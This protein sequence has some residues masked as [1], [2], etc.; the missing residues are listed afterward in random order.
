MLG[1]GISLW[2]QRRAA[3]A[4]L[5]PATLSPHLWLDPSDLTTLF[6]NSNGTGAVAADN[7]PVGYIGDKSGNGN[8]FIEA[9]AAARPIYKTSAGLSWLAF[10]GVDDSIGGPLVNGFITEAV[11]DIFCAGIVNTIATDDPSD[12]PTFNDALFSDGGGLIGLHFRQSAPRMCAFNYDGSPDT[13]NDD[14]TA[15][16][17]F[18][19]HIRHSG[20]NLS[21]TQNA[22]AT[23]T[24]ASG[25]TGSVINPASIGRNRTDT[26]H[27]WTDCKFYG[28][29]ARKTIFSA[30]EVAALKT[31]MGAKVG[32]VL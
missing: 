29:I 21:L 6:Q 12:Q 13:A 17:A 20:G 16:E 11:Y 4:V 7:D 10:D 28:M 18:V 24:V 14:Y 5:D 31:Y 30:G 27:A 8:H 26:S 1:L 32:L 15:G 2:G 3:A 23:V 19:A 9:T 25:D 22:R